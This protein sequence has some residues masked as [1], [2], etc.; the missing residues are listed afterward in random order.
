MAFCSGAAGTGCLSA[1]AFVVWP[2]PLGRGSFTLSFGKELQQ[3]RLQR[4]VSLS[5]IAGA[6]KVSERYLRALEEGDHANLP[7]GVFNKG[8]VRSY[9]RY[10][11]LDEEEWLQRFAAFSR[12]EGEEDWTEFARNVKRN[13]DSV[14]PRTRLRWL[15]VLLMLAVLA[16]IGWAAWHFVIK[17]RLGRR[18][19]DPTYNVYIQH[20]TTR[21]FTK[22][23]SVSGLRAIRD[24]DGGLPWTPGPLFP[25]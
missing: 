10:L 3:E 24:G 20:E 16:G 22:R 25:C 2:E 19:A 8:I 12:S 18:T 11:G 4:D 21:P 7:G 6:T 13:R 1:A 17:P 23:I 5:S 15:G 14:N 9:C